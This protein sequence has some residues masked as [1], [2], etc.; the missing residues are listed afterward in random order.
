[1]LKN[2]TLIQIQLFKMYLFLYQLVRQTFDHSPDFKI[3]IS[4]DIKMSF[5]HV[6]DYVTIKDCLRGGEIFNH[7]VFIVKSTETF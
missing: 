5:F 3:S 7:T 6:A 4:K 2:I 1:M